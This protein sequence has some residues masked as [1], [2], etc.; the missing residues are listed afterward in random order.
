MRLEVRVV[1]QSAPVTEWVAWELRH[2][3]EDGELGVDI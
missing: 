2:D 3:L 1:V